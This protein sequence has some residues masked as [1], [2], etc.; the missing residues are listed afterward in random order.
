MVKLVNTSFEIIDAKTNTQYAK[1]IEL[2][3]RNCYK[4]EGN[5]TETS[6]FNMVEK[7][8]KLGH[9]AMLEHDIMTVKFTMDVGA[10]KD[11]TRHR[12]CAYAI[13]ST[14]WCCY[15]NDKFGNELTFI[16]PVHIPE[17]TKL[18]D[19]WYKHRQ[20][21]E[22]AYLELVEEASKNS[23]SV[24]GINTS[25]VD[26]GRMELSHSLK[27]DVVV[28]ANLREWRHIFKTRCDVHAHPTL[29]SL[30]RDF[31]CYCVLMYPTFFSDLSYLVEDKLQDMMEKTKLKV[32]ENK[33]LYDSNMFKKPFK[34]VDMMS[35]LCAN[36]KVLNTLCFLSPLIANEFTDVCWNTNKDRITLHINYNDNVSDNY[37]EKVYE[38]LKGYILDIDI[39]VGSVLLKQKD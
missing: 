12:L 3:A 37:V 17:N 35:Y 32:F 34:S 29:R 22:A 2:C 33:L 11:L 28:T 36:Q 27:A 8:I 5:I 25:K 4:S 14:R 30:M 24:D 6:C 21:E 16:K 15:S 31:L 1:K 9:E 10:Y 38:M 13:E 20:Q 23:L 26:I 7:L 39:Y 18:F 19:L